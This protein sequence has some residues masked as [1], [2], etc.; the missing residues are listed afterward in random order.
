MRFSLPFRRIFFSVLLSVLLL[1]LEAPSQELRLEPGHIINITVLGYPELSQSVVVRQDGTVDYPLLA[2]IPVFGMTQTEFSDMLYPL[3]TRYVERPRLFVF[4][5]EHKMLTLRIQGQVNQ[6]GIYSAPGP[7]D[8]QGA[9]SLAGGP[10]EMADLEHIGIIR[11]LGDLERELTIDLRDFLEGDAPLTS[12]PMMEDGD[13]VLVRTM[14]IRSYVRVMG[15]VRLPGNYIALKGSN[16]IDM[17]N[18]AGG[19]S[20]LG[21][22]NDVV[23]V[24]R[25]DGKY[26]VEEYHL[27]AMIE[28]GED[29]LIPEVQ[30]GD[31]IV[32]SEYAE[33]K[34][35]SF[36]ARTV[37]DL[38]MLVSSAIILSR[39]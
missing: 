12:L 29:V 6:P 38:V 7:M 22:L 8:I 18:Q 39:L 35:L 4:V 23:F 36:W 24:S 14:D 34:Q 2:N 26:R 20:P 11:R 31:V 32:V 5:S 27:R 28:A 9:L 10:T 3:L 15:A 17:I 37:R 1:A 25:R 30:S 21:N 19:V 13:V 16:I 33:W